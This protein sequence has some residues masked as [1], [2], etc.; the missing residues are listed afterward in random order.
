MKTLK[1]L[2]TLIILIFLSNPIFSQITSYP[3]TTTFASGFGDW[4]Q[5]G[6]DDFD[7]T[8]TTSGTPSAGT[9]PQS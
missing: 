6:T 2:S 4:N 1:I 9:G 3:H 7:W 5:S 8:Q